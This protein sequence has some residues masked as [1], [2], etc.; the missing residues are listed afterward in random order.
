MREKWEAFYP[1]ATSSLLIS[2][3]TWNRGTNRGTEMHRCKELGP[4]GGLGWGPYVQP[5]PLVQLHRRWSRAERRG[6]RTGGRQP[7]GACRNGWDPEEEEE[8]SRSERQVEAA[9]ERWVRETQPVSGFANPRAW[10]SGTTLLIKMEGSVIE[11]G[12]QWGNLLILG[13]LIGFLSFTHSLSCLHLF[14]RSSKKHCLSIRYLSL[15]SFRLPE[16]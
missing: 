3:L 6:G 4:E 8:G 10:D 7:Q 14:I 13:T 15:L 2:H 9:G 1:P 11:A 5:C 12:S 16:E